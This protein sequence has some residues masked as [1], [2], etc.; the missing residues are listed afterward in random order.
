MKT[1]ITFDGA[2]SGNPGPGGWAALIRNQD[3]E[4]TVS[5]SEPITTNNRM[6]LLAAICG[7]ESVDPGDVEMVGDSQYVIDGFTKWMPS[8]KAKGWKRGQKPVANLDLWQALD[9][10]VSRH[11]SVIWSW[12]RGHSGHADNERV[13]GIARREVSKLRKGG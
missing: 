1:V 13:D 2:C 4:R 12:T 8:W 11:K 10:A 3:G 9:A 6:E 5:G 7:L